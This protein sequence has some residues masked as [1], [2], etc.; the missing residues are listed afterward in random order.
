MQ[1]GRTVWWARRT[2]GVLLAFAI[3]GLFSAS[4][5]GRSEAQVGAGAVATAPA[6]ETFGVAVEEPA[7]FRRLVT[8][9]M[10]KRGVHMPGFLYVMAAHQSDDVDAVL[11]AL[12]DATPILRKALDAGTT[13]GLL[14]TPVARPVFRRRLV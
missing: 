12:G 6:D 14:E 7:P 2:L 13:E 4:W 8:Q 5:E 10:A 9:E 1:E 3:A 11:D